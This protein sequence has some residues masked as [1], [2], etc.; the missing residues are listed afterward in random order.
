M[1][2]ESETKSIMT[3]NIFYGWSDVVDEGIRIHV[4]AEY[5]YMQTILVLDNAP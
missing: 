3:G 4:T 1:T 2:V 5:I